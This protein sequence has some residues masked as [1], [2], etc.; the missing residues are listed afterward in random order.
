M[1]N[2]AAAAASRLSLKDLE[3]SGVMLIGGGLSHRSLQVGLVSSHFDCTHHIIMSYDQLLY[4][5]CFLQVLHR[6]GEILS[7]EGCVNSPLARVLVVGN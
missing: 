7:S 5:L 2:F 1:H 4:N 3:L 6:T